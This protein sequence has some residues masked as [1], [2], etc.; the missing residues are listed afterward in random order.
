MFTTESVAKRCI[1]F[2][3]LVS[4]AGEGGF[5]RLDEGKG[6]PSKTAWVHVRHGPCYGT[7]PE[8]EVFIYRD[9]W[10]YYR[11]A[12]HVAVEGWRKRHLN[13]AALSEIQ[14]ALLAGE[15][16]DHQWSRP[17][18]LSDA[19]TVFVDLSCRGVVLHHEFVPSTAPPLDQLVAKIEAISGIETLGRHR[20]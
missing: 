8:Y 14:S 17:A 4:C 2:L 7:C 20:Y 16:C 5:V 11:G 10:V 1:L 9:G 3:L 18:S 13:R 6:A 19:P 15:A 12:E